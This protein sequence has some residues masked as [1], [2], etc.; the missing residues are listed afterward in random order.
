VNP[1][2]WKPAPSD[3]KFKGQRTYGYITFEA[4]VDAVAEINSGAKTAADFEGVL[5]T[6]GSIVGATAIL[7][8]GRKSLDWGGRPME[9]VYNSD[10]VHATPTGMRAV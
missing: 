4:F 1:L 3:G 6:V 7:E 8:A 5:P 2:F 9:L 10:D